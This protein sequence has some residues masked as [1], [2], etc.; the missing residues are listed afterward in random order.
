[1]PD[2]DPTSPGFTKDVRSRIE[3]GVTLFLDSI[4]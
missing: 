2:L 4:L 3:Y 1:M